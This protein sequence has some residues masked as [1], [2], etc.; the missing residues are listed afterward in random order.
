MLRKAFTLIELMVVVAIIA[1]IAAI[2]IP[3]FLKARESARQRQRGNFNQVLPVPKASEPLGRL[4]EILNLQADLRLQHWSTQL[5]MDVTNRYKLSYAGNVT[6]SLP[7]NETGEGQVELQ[8]P[9]PDKTEEAMN[10]R[11]QRSDIGATFSEVRDWR[12]G[13]QG[14]IIPLRL[15]PKQSVDLRVFFEAQGRDRMILPLPPA[16]RLNRVQL[17]LTCAQAGALL[18]EASLQPQIRNACGFDWRFENLVSQ[19]PLIVDLPGSH[20]LT[21]KVLLLCR[22]AGLAVLLFGFGFWYL[23]E[24][25]R[26]GCLSRFGWGHFFMLA[27]TYSS[28]FPALCILSLSQGLSLGPALLIAGGLAQPL[29]LLHV[30][31]SLDLRFSLFYVLPLADFTLGLVVN[32]VFGEN[33]RDLIFMGAGFLVVGLAT[34]TYPRW[35]ANRQTWRDQQSHLL[36]Q[37]LRALLQQG[38]ELSQAAA[39]KQLSS[40]VRD[41]LQRLHNDLA[42]L[43]CYSVHMDPQDLA[44]VLLSVE[45]QERVLRKNQ[46]SL[47]A[48]PN[49]VESSSQRTER[50]HCL[51][52]GSPGEPTSIFCSQCGARQAV[53]VECS[54]GQKY[55]KAA[56]QNPKCHCPHCGKL[57]PNLRQGQV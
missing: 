46:S 47:Q 10:V 31:R 16:L 27:L 41:S 12:L 40:Q 25:Y 7:V 24:L 44:Q 8:L 17:H 53:A 50:I 54:C 2:L 22:L 33:W 49:K 30:W 6:V 15:Q 35:R 52:C 38:D 28:F 36:Q 5:G 13:Q 39:S 37:R 57:E 26:P 29:L 20:S 1:I 14:L 21:G 42:A 48:A 18:A 43:S 4:P 11:V 34:L 3:N 51:S 55:W 23:G 56:W 32:G 45:N 9:F 19:S